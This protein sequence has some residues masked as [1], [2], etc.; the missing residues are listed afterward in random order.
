MNTP[1]RDISGNIFL[2]R[3]VITTFVALGIVW[4]FYI[5]PEPRRMISM[6]PHNAAWVSLSY[7]LNTTL[8]EMKDHP[9]LQRFA[10]YQ[11]ERLV[12]MT[13]D[14]HPGPVDAYKNPL[15]LDPHVQEILSLVADKECAVAFV[16]ALSDIP[17][18]MNGY[19]AA[20]PAWVF[21]S[22]IGSRSHVLRNYLACVDVPELETKGLPFGNVYWYTRTAVTPD[23]QYL[24]FTLLE[25]VLAACLSRDKHAIEH[26]IQTADFNSSPPT[27]MLASPEWSI[28]S[29]QWPEYGEVSFWMN[30]ERLR[31]SGGASTMVSGHMSSPA[32]MPVVLSA[33]FEAPVSQSAAM[34]QVAISNLGKLLGEDP[35]SVVLWSREALWR[36]FNSNRPKPAWL[37]HLNERLD[38]FTEDSSLVFAAG[39]SEDLNG[40]LLDLHVPS[41]VM[42]LRLNQPIDLEKHV[43]MV[44]DAYNQ[45]FK[46]GLIP[47]EDGEY[48]VIEGTRDNGYGQQTHDHSIAVVV[49][50]HWLLV[51]SDFTSLKQ[52]VAR[53]TQRNISDY[54]HTP[55]WVPKADSISVHAAWLDMERGGK[56]LRSAA[57]AYGLTQAGSR[58]YRSTVKQ[59]ERVSAC[60]DALSVLGF[61]QYTL[62]A[63][64]QSCH[65]TALSEVSGQKD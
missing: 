38:S 6:I 32:R 60:V 56:A 47:V 37:S 65:L 33:E 63:D 64:G 36:S 35:N 22:W 43:S 13:G 49:I 24:G 2:R 53:Y 26:V 12:D 1:G 42:G 40:R 17:D 34:D 15:D 51:G 61:F 8:L 59:I 46:L 54:A 4:V 30:W 48:I 39:F 10:E 52:L 21:Y 58:S 27:A 62:T 45:D 28:K 11:Q 31:K 20:Q 7:D 50:D 29:L 16:P 19:L 44:L 14:D 3:L 23:G 5:P 18:S 41:V 9:A 55:A 57:S 25:G